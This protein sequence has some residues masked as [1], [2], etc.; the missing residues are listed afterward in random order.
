MRPLVSIITVNYNQTQVTRE[1][2][3]SLRQVSYPAIEVILV[4]NASADASIALLKEEFPEITYIQTGKNLGFAGGNN[5]GIR[6][7]KGSLIMLLNNDVEVPSGFL[8][9]IVDVFEKN[10]GVGMASP[11]VLYPD[12]KTIQYAGAVGI[13]PLTGRGRR[14]GLFEQD[15]GQYDHI[16]KTD[17]GHGAALMIRRSVIDEVGLMP[18]LYFL[19]YEEHDW[20]EQVK[21]KGYQM[22]YVG[23]SS[24]IHK[25]SMSTGGDD[26]YLKV[27]YLNRNRLL[28]MR[29]NFKG[30]AYLVGV[31]FL[32]MFAIPKKI[33]TYLGRGK[34]TLIKA[35]F[36]GIAWNLSNPKIKNT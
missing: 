35:L 7:A 11:K 28:F 27:H 31:V 33:I 26:S 2:L 14:I 8:E 36:D 5:V 15:S 20:C 17:L 12:G 10:P 9:P 4:D 29:R 6:A 25:E 22:F 19:Y 13:K 18:E 1:L 32:F 24:V 3:K 34:P 30:L 21:R 23:S 16:G